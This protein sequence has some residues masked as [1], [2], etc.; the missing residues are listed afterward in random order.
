MNNREKVIYNEALNFLL[1]LKGKTKEGKLIQITP[2]TIDPYLMPE[3]ARKIITSSDLFRQLIDSLKNRDRMS[4]VIGDTANF[5]EL[6][7]D[8]NPQEVHERYSQNTNE[9]LS[10]I[11]KKFPRAINK[12]GKRSLWYQFSKGALSSAA[13]A[14]NFS[15]DGEFDAFVKQFSFNEYSKAALPMLLDYEIDGF[16]FALACNFLKDAGYSD[17]AKPDVHLI[18]IFYELGLSSSSQPYDVFKNILRFAKEVNKSPYAVDKV[19]WLIGSGKFYLPQHAFFTGQ[20]RDRF[21]QL[22]KQKEKSQ[23]E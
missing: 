1:G 14:K 8:F 4:N 17:Y 16:G 2:E 6:L 15:K 7:F 5:K 23:A 11:Q 13:F 21:I 9:L 3:P 10:A 12:N 19:F 18:K 22:I 20:N